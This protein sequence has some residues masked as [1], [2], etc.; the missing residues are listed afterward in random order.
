MGGGSGQSFGAEIAVDPP[1]KI[2]NSPFPD[3]FLQ[4]FRLLFNI[5]GILLLHYPG[6]ELVVVVQRRSIHR[7]VVAE[8]GEAHL[9]AQQAGQR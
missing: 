5:M 6:G 1:C 7:E 2:C 8:A 3:Q 4:E 9:V